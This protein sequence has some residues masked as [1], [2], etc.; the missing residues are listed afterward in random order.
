[1][2][3]LGRKRLSR[4]PDSTYATAFARTPDKAQTPTP[5]CFA[6]GNEPRS[7]GQSAFPQCRRVLWCPYKG[8]SICRASHAPFD[9]A[10]RLNP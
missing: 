7:C 8:Q 9:P 10:R 3:R 6:L 2:I 4:I 1:M 5:P